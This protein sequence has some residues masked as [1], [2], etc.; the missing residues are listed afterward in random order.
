[1][2]LWL[3]PAVV[4]GHSVGFF[5]G[6]GRTRGW[7]GN[8]A[9]AL[10]RDDAVQPLHPSVIPTLIDNCI[11]KSSLPLNTWNHRVSGIGVDVSRL[12]MVSRK[13]IC[14]CQPNPRLQLPC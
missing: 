14:L 2:D 13:E 10:W 11:V 5:E 8:L 9:R 6:Q 7:Q 4:W 1:M 12:R 3:G